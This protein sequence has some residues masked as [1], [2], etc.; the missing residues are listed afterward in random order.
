M[1]AQ[2]IPAA[3]LVIAGRRDDR[4]YEHELYE[5]VGQLGM[6]DHV[7]FR[8]N[9]NDDE[10]RNLLNQSQTLALPS[11]VEG[12]GIVVLEANALGVPVVASSG[13]PESAVQEGVNG[14]RYP[15]GDMVGLSDAIIRVLSDSDFREKLSAGALLFARRFRWVEVGAQFESVVSQ[16]ASQRQL[17]RSPTRG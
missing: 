15:F 9:I 16:L 11:A 6:Q 1:V 12:F 7:E 2:E 10:K 14:T 8:F 4:R 13:V 5:L 3:R 17:Q